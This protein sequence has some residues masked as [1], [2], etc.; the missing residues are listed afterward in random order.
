MGSQPLRT[1]SGC[2]ATRAVPVFGSTE[3]IVPN[4]GWPCVCTNASACA[5]IALTKRS[6]NQLA[7]SSTA[8]VL[9]EPLLA[10]ICCKNPV[11]GRNDLSMESI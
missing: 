7:A 1:P 10:R 6:I 9:G 5:L 4:R 2:I 11:L 3:V 8:S